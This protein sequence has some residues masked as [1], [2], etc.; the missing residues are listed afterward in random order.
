MTTVRIAMWSGPRNI[1]TAMMRAWENR[2]DTV[3][4]DEPFYAHYLDHTGD[5]HPLKQEVIDA[6][7]C[8][9]RKVVNALLAPVAD[10]KSIFFQKHMTHHLLDHIDRD[11]LGL[12]VNCFLI[13]DPAEVVASYVQKRDRVTLADIGIEQQARIFDYVCDV[14]GITPPV[15]DAKDIL[16]DPAAVLTRLCDRIG[17]PFTETMLSWPAG[18]RDS[19]GVWG[20]HWY[21]AVEASTGF[22]TYQPKHIRLPREL[23]RLADQSRTHYERMWSARITG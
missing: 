8:D 21:G 18:T 11:W 15:L 19:D 13:R 10:G 6:G 22:A 12:V 17:V 2:D 9:W 5:E 14:S 20:K 16:L 3:V 7:E 23:M 4:W 1:S